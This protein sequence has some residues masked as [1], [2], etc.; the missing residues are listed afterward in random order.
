[1]RARGG[2]DIYIYIY[3]QSFLTQA[4]DGSEWSALRPS[5]FNSGQIPRRPVTRKLNV[6]CVVGPDLPY[7]LNQKIRQLTAVI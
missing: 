3:I 2:A 5:R 1:M 7:L 6:L 4:L